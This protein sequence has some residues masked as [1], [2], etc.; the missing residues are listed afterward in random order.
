MTVSL[1]DDLI[2]EVDA[3]NPPTA[4]TRPA[5]PPK[6]DP[7]ADA[8]VA[9]GFATNAFMLTLGGIRAANTMELAY[10]WSLPSR[11]FQFPV[12][13]SNEHEEGPRRIFVRHPLLTEHPL[14]KHIEATIGIKISADDLSHE[15]AEWWHAV[16][17][18]SAGQWRELLETRRFTTDDHIASAASYGLEY[19]PHDRNRKGYISTAEA[20]EIMAAINSS[21]PADRQAIIF[22]HLMPPSPVKSEKGPERWPINSSF[23]EADTAANRAWAHI[24]GIEAGW[25]GYD[26]SGFLGWTVKGR[27]RFGALYTT[28]EPITEPPLSAL[29]DAIGP[30]PG[31]AIQLDLFI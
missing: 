2:T 3:T 27:Q 8:L 15:H 20:R 12:E 7:L 23:S 13:L 24:I 22:E 17:L 28:P 21:E 14:V 10:P 18:I 26:R 6:P 19:S 9:H 1:F 31:A 16:D 11:M 4:K 5:I 25:F 29:A 30:R